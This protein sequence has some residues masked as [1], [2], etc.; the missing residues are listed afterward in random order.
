MEKVLAYLKCPVIYRPV[1]G[2]I[3]LFKWQQEEQP[4]GSVVQDNRLDKIFFAKQVRYR[5]KRV[6]TCRR[7]NVT[8]FQGGEQ[9]LRE[10][11]EFL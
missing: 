1:H 11:L 10:Y 2:L 8:Y 5:L 3:F 9:T 4:S 7:G 6:F